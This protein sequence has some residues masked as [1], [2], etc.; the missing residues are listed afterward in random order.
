[1]DTFEVTD[2]FHK[3]PWTKTKRVEVLPCL[4]LHLLIWNDRSVTSPSN[5]PLY[6]IKGL[7]TRSKIKRMK[8]TLQ[9]L[10][11]KIKEKE[12]Q[13]ELRVAPNW[14]TFLQINEYAFRST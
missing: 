6:E 13:C 8:Q 14:T 2:F 9:G 5:D 7:M 11:L 4:L 12:D 1:M 3:S 10:I